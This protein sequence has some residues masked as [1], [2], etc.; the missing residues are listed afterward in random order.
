M[1]TGRVDISTAFF[2]SERGCIPGSLRTGRHRLVSGQNLIHVGRFAQMVIRAQPGRGGADRESDRA[3]HAPASMRTE[4]YKLFGV[5]VTQ[6][7]GL[8]LMALA[9][10]SEVGPDMSRWPTAGHLD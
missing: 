1:V 10:F 7:P 2:A 4:A 6:I 9:W 3:P 8:M 5:E